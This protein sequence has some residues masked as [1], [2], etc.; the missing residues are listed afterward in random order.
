MKSKTIWL[1]NSPAFHMARLFEGDWRGSHG[2]VRFF[3]NLSLKEAREE[4][5]N[6]RKLIKQGIHPAQQKRL[7]RIKS[8]LEQANTFETIAKEWLALKDWELVKKPTGPAL[9]ENRRGVWTG[10]KRWQAQVASCST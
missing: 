10:G 8:G 7:D 6:A 5:E 3:H 1:I 9:C 2:T 4:A